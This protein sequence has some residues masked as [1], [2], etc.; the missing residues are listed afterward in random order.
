MGKRRLVRHEGMISDLFF[1]HLSKILEWHILG[2][3]FEDEDLARRR[4][5]G[6]HAA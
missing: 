2:N 1:Q 6:E 5:M 4:I 3:A